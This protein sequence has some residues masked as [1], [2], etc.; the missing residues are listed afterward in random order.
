MIVDLYTGE[1]AF[2]GLAFRDY[3]SLARCGDEDIPGCTAISSRLQYRQ[4]EGGQVDAPKTV[5]YIVDECDAVPLS[6]KPPRTKNR[7]RPAGPLAVDEGLFLA[8][9]D[10]VEDQVTEAALALAE[11]L[12]RRFPSASK[13][14]SL[15]LVYPQFLVGDK[16]EDDI[17][18]RVTAIIKQYGTDCILQDGHVVPAM[19]DAKLLLEQQ[20]DYFAV[21]PEAALDV[22]AESKGG[23]C[24]QSTP[25]EVAAITLLW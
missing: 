20:A 13:L 2:R 9:R 3:Q 8:T 5:H 12:E 21:A 4:E 7:G 16:E 23:E 17:N 6:A 11:E 25:K 15:A 24:S 19:I 10:F 22:M 14:S 1:D 18:M